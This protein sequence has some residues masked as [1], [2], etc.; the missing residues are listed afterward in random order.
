MFLLLLIVVAG[1]NNS[2]NSYGSQIQ[3]CLLFNKNLRK[4]VFL[5][6]GVLKFSVIQVD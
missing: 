2:N 3:V 6:L 1:S 4:L 5:P